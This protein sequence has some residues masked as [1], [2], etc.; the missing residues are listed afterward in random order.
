MRANP[1]ISVIVP[2]YNAERFLSD[3]LESILAQDYSDWEAILVDDG[4]KDSSPALCDEFSKKDARVK[5][6]HKENGGVSSARNFGLDKAMGEWVFFLDADDRMKPYAL[7]S[8]VAKSVDSELVFGGY[9]VFDERNNLTYV[10]NERE[11]GKMD[12]YQA[13]EQM[14]KPWYYRYYG[15]VWGKLFKMAVIKVYGLL[16]DERIAF[17]EDRL[18]TVTYICRIETVAFFTAPIYEYVENSSSAMASLSKAYNPKFFTDLDAFRKMKKEL[19]RLPEAERVIPLMKA[20]AGRS[21][22]RLSQMIRGSGVKRK[23]LQIRLYT[24]MLGILSFKEFLDGALLPLV[25]RKS[26]VS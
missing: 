5:V 10:I 15:Y 2:V 18:F 11:E 25:I 23:K 4:S 21:F 14:F 3:C 6:F 16:F 24:K 22:S 17:N 12:K 1:T 19:Y 20:E 26:Q 8:M 13:L 9:E 7:S